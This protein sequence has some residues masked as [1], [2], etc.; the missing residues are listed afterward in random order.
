LEVSISSK[1]YYFGNNAMTFSPTL[2]KPSVQ[3]SINFV[4]ARVST[5][6]PAMAA[7]AFL[8]KEK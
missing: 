4:L 1:F 3:N 7:F 5:Q 2:Y 6:T 8:V